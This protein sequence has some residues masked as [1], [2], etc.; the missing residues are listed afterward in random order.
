MKRLKLF[1]FYLLLITLTSCTL[2]YIPPVL[3]TQELPVK[4][5]I[6]GSKGL[7]LDQD[8]L[9]LSLKLNQIPQEG[10]LMIQWFSDTNVEAASDAQ[11]I[12]ASQEGLQVYYLLPSQ[13]ALTEGTWRTVVSF[14]DK[15]IR[16]FS[17]DIVRK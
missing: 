13:V 4:L 12:Q 2:L 7:F 3:E 15:L 8:K 6:D 5:N 11:W 14:Q 9:V 1:I 16:Q 17:L 10:W